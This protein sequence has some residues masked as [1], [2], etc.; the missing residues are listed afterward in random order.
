MAGVKR[1][2]CVVR[3]D[4][5]DISSALLP[6]L[7]KLRIVDKAG[8]SSDTIAIDLDDMDGAILLPREGVEIEA[9]LGDAMTGP[10]VVFRGT[11]DSAR[12]TGSRSDGRVLTIN[13]KGFDSKGKAKEPHEKHWDDKSLKDVFEDA[14]RQAGIE[15]V[16]VDEALAN[17]QRPYWAM[18]GESFIHFGE[19]LAR[20][21]SGTFKISG[22][23]AI[24][25]KR[26][27]GRTPGGDAL[28]PIRASYGVNLLSWDIAPFDGRPR[29]KKTKARW[30]DPKTA[31]WQVEDV[32]VEDDGAVAEF[33]GR[34]AAADEGEAKSHAES[35]KTDSER[36]KGGGSITIDGAADAQ[37]EGEVILEGARPGIDGTYRIDAVNHEFDRNSGWTTRLDLK[38]PHGEAGKDR[39]GADG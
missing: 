16:R 12:S 28:P 13:G 1:T 8:T 4:G 29:Y 19:R 20:E 6:R 23:T 15:N 2:T 14:A 3:V 27:G 18:Q 39:R 38:Q 36:G 22:K 25:A 24:L 30:Y 17:V 31:T 26:N 9:L 5:R 37:P 10:V 34:F 21:V 33:T 32:E 35:R 7:L 11:V